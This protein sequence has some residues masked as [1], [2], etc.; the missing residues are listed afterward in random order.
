[1]LQ[2]MPPTTA[3]PLL[4]EDEHLLVLNK[5]PDLLSVPGRG[6][7]G[8]YNLAALVQAQFSDALVVHRLDMATSGLMIFARGLLA[9]QRLSLAFEQRRVSKRYV[10][11]VRGWVPADSGSVCA[12]LIVDWPRR[13]LQI[14]SAE[15]GKP[16]LTHW[17]VLQR[18]SGEGPRTRLSLTPVT[19]RSHQLR[20]HMQHIG[21]PIVG[22]DLYGGT[23]P[24]SSRLLLH[25]AEIAF[26]HPANGQACR[27]ESSVPF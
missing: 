25:A 23:G 11:V 22:D 6:E 3:L 10:A 24:D 19:G 1:M 21:H 27:F 17:Q 7:A 5:P 14:V 15:H 26:E 13:P 16:A 2:P 8:Q 12:P 9:Q 4:H 20:V 18:D